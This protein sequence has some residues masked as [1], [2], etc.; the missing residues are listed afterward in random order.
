MVR[1]VLRRA[2]RAGDLQAQ[3]ILDPATRSDPFP[4]HDRIR[5]QGRLVRG[6]LSYVSASH[7]ACKQVLRSDDF[8]T[9]SPATRLPPV[10]ERVAAWSRRPRALGPV[11]APSLLAVEPPEHTR[12]RRLVS[13]VFTAR[14][15]ESLRERVRDTAEHLLDGL[16]HAARAGPVDLVAAYCSQLPLTVIAEILGVPAQDRARVLEFGHGA[17]PS[18]DVGLTWREFRQVDAALH[19]FDT[20]LGDHLER[21][22]RNP[23]SDLLSQLVTVEEEGQRLNEGELRATAGLLLAA[24]FETTVNL[25]GS[26]TELLL[27]HPAQLAVLREHP[28][29]WSNAVEEVLRF[30]SP[31]Q[32][33]ARVAQ[34]DTAVLGV[35]VCGRDGWS[36][37]CCPGRTATQRCS[38]THTASTSGAPTP[39]ST[40]R[41]RRAGTSAWVRRWRASRA[42]WGYGRCS[43]A[44]LTSPWL[45]A[46]SGARPAYC[47]GGGSCRCCSANTSPL[48]D[49]ARRGPHGSPPGRWDRG[50]WPGRRASSTF[51][52]L[53]VLSVGDATRAAQAFCR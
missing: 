2:A 11:E 43:S 18:L 5:S 10:V 14:A 33:T 53:G 20:W 50:C 34:R 51:L 45:P 30:E 9:G 31:V 24:G 8:R 32:V 4:T 49:R 40:C 42:R 16:D 12:Y 41:S 36:R 37:R 39:A 38:P 7:A 13:T 1:A 25:L 22:R 23:G 26:G 15:V 35:P 52:V 21:L 48:G 29:L 3:L 27:R 44:S 17:A 28:A 46:R 47:G 6:K 19:A